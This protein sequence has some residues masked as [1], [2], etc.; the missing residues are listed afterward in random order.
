M[1]SVD[2]SKEQFTRLVT[3]DGQGVQAE[4]FDVKDR[5]GRDIGA[6]VVLQRVVFEAIPEAE[7]KRDEYGF[8]RPG[9]PI[10][11]KA[12]GE[13]FTF[14]PSALRD[15]KMYGALQEPRYFPAYGNRNAAI[16]KYFADAR[17]RAVKN[18]GK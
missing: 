14:T 5:F 18:A 15:G 9:Y 7:T 17:K 3:R 16:K 10:Y 6:Q 1:A 11:L 8:P 2:Y 13:Y 12:P 4:C